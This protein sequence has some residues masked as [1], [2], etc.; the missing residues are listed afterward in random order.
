MIEFTVAGWAAYAPG[1]PSRAAWEDWAGRPGVPG[2]ADTPAL[3]EI[4]A[5]MRRRIERLGR[6]AIQ[7]ALWCGTS[8]GVPIVFASRHGDVS[9]SWGLLRN[10][11]AGEGMSPTSFG[12]SVHNAIGALYSILQRER[13]N[14]TAL[15]AGR[16]TAE[17]ALI[18][19]AGL[20]ADGAEEVLVVVYDAPVPEAFADFRDEPD[21]FYAW[22]WRVRDGKGEGVRFA[23][24]PVEGMDADPPDT[25]LPAGLEVLRF[26]LSGER[27]LRRAVD[28]RGWCWR[29]RD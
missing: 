17:A 7:A 6:M 29:R 27:S 3:P 11:T 13:A 18:E 9:R 12:L 4:P 14:Y 8:P 25:R 21:P 2:G 19:A 23:L 15:A 1:L 20:L 5:L 22:A 16:L 10:L 26:M 28:G 24:E